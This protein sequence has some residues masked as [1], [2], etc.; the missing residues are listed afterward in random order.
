MVNSVM[1][2]VKTEDLGKPTPCSKWDVNALCNHILSET[3]WIEPLLAGK[4]IAE[5][6]TALDGDLVQGKP[7]EAWQRYMQSAVNAASST[8]PETTAHLSY[9]DK[10]VTDY[11]NEVGGDLIVHGWDLARAVGVEYIIDDETARLI[12]KGAE[13]TMPMAREAGLFASEVVPKPDCSQAEKLLAA[14]GRDIN[15]GI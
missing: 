14:F 9:T 10:P 3:A 12:Q 4:T 15:W 1:R 8:P 2:Q 13:P 7:L 11:L 6:G 5:V